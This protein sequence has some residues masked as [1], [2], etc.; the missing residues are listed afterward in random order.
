MIHLHFSPAYD[1]NLWCGPVQPGSGQVGERWVGE[2]GLLDFLEVQLGLKGPDVAPE[3]RRLAHLNAIKDGEP[4]F[5][6]RSFEVD[7][8]A[9]SKRLLSVRDRLI[10][11]GWDGKPV[12]GLSKVADLARL[13]ALFC[14]ESGKSD[15]LRKVEESLTKTPVP[16]GLSR[17]T[18]ECDSAE[19]SFRLRKIFSALRA[20]GVAI[21]SRDWNSGPAHA[22]AGDL[23][24][25][26][27]LHHEA[28]APKGDGSVRLVTARDPWESARVAAA[29]VASLSAEEQA[30]AVIVCPPRNRGILKTAFEARGI[31]FG[32]DH[33]EV[34][35]ARPPL[36]ILIL[37]L[38]LAWDPKDPSAALALVTIEG[39]PVSSRFRSALIGSFEESLVVGGPKWNLALEEALSKALTELN[40]EEEKKKL[41]DRAARVKEWFSAPA[42]SYENGIP[43]GDVIAI[44]KRV[45]RWFQQRYQ[46][47]GGASVRG[48]IEIANLLGNLVQNLKE[49]RITRER[50][51]SLLVEAVEDGVS[52]NGVAA[53]ARGPFVVERPEAITAPASTVIW[54]DFNS[55]AAHVS[56]DAFFS[57]AE[58]ERLFASKIEWPD[59]AARAVSAGK[60]FHRPVRMAQSQMV[61]FHSLLNRSGDP[62][63]VHPLWFELF[64]E[65]IRKDWLSA[66]EVRLTEQDEEATMKFLTS[67]G[68]IEVPETPELLSRPRPDWKVAKDSLG[69]RPAESASSLEKLLGC[70]LAYVLQYPARLRGEDRETLEYTDRTKGLIAHEVLAKVFSEGAP[71][72]PDRAKALAE[73]L[74]PEVA[75]D[76][77]PSLF[78]AALSTERLFLRDR[79]VRAAESYARLLEK[80]HLT[81]GAT[82][83][84]IKESNHKIEGVSITGVIDHVL[85]TP[86]GAQIIVD[87]K[88][89]KGG[90]K[91]SAL[92]E[93]TSL[94][95]ALYSLLI[96][97]GTPPV[98]AYHMINDRELLVLNQSLKD[99]TEVNG[100]EVREVLE[101]A[102]ASLRAAKEILFSGVLRAR[103]WDEEGTLPFEAPCRYC[104]FDR[105]CGK[106]FEEKKK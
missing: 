60:G 29:F 89:G 79:V 56:H 14:D 34:S 30:N 35:Y 48:T 28:I 42:H 58:I 22:N 91:K 27:R 104:E 3:V 24:A 32:G 50:L 70:E 92:E 87:H 100:P 57:R 5:W 17:I 52:S 45:T 96:G 1:S 55:S 68:A 77:A 9:A 99:A 62:D 2:I 75:R 65:A 93:G 31:P 13:E 95:L 103:G 63:G 7:P 33:A 76:F 54:W 10:D 39:S 73:D 88:W 83:V 90:Y 86:T 20:A 18:I 46:N 53:Q 67:I 8:V 36:Q 25:L 61:F 72:I 81:V 84:E 85:K 105:I 37:A 80:N 6:S 16:C 106:F 23:S 38:T 97:G 26:P 51:L 21:E 41:E 78:Q 49:P 102:G 74:F 71:P 69:L 4:G 66:I 94:Q 15:R 19:Q 64:P 47:E 101:R 44:V 43:A 40:D 82:E 98:L 11:S 12:A 59:D